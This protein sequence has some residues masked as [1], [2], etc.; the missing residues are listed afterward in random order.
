VVLWGETA[1]QFATIVGTTLTVVSEATTIVAVESAAASQIRFSIVSYI[2][3][4]IS[5]YSRVRSRVP[6]VILT[7]T[8]A[9]ES[10]M[11]PA[12]MIGTVSGAAAVLAIFAGIAVFLIRGK[13]NTFQTLSVPD[14]PC[15]R[16]R[17]TILRGSSESG[18]VTLY[19]ARQQGSV[20]L[21]NIDSRLV[22]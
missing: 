17:V 2:P 14:V 8:P 19:T 15:P 11:G 10:G 12:R 5:T 9:V 1:T 7:E 22:A 6:V 20:K 13:R 4:H 18:D 16:G 3:I 21:G